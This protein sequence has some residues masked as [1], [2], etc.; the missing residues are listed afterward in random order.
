FRPDGMASRILGMGDV[1]ELVQKAQQHINADDAKNQQ[2]R[3]AEG[4]YNLNDFREQ[5]AQVGKM[6]SMKQI[7]EMLPGASKLTQDV[8]VD[9]ESKR[10]LT[11]INSM[12]KKERANPEIIDAGRRRRIARGCGD[13]FE[14][15]EV[16][17]LIKQFD[18]MRS[19]MK[20]MA[21][22]SMMD[23][24]KKMMG[25]ANS[26][27]LAAGESLKQKERSARNPM[28]SKERADLRKKERQRKKQNRKKH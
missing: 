20:Q 8:D 5:M 10:F 28:N 22:M 4:K 7:M 17:K 12:T 6:G 26:G 27:A 3:V 24:M 16:N 1:V 11:I 9:L 13:G 15:A 21:N 25:L 2:K 23:R 14:P 18:Q 19:M